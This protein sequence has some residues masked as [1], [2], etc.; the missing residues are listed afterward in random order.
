LT[1]TRLPAAD[2]PFDQ[3]RRD[4]RVILDRRLR[5]HLTVWLGRWP[6]NGPLDVVGSV[7]RAEPG[8]D[9]RIHPAIGVRAPTG[10]VVS[11][12]PERADDVRELAKRVDGSL[13]GLLAELPAAVG[14][15]ARGAFRAVFRWTVNPT[16]LP[17][18]GTWMSADD[19]AVPGWLRVFG[20]EVL[21]AVDP[22]TGA[23]LAGVG[24]KRHDM[25]GHELSVGTDPA[26]RGRGLA[27]RLV[28]QAARRVLDDGAVPTYQHSVG[29]VASAKVAE[30]AGLRDVGWHSFGVSEE[31][32]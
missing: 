15:P 6:A 13:D 1:R 25:Y 32:K 22:Q 20:G 19:E 12:P 29:N 10:A 11:V 14:F 27:R 8:W 3:S 4:L 31:G 5:H 2:R 26:A 18:A 23:Y 24:I 7:R 17:D 30:V 28:A 9:G 16:P 21:V